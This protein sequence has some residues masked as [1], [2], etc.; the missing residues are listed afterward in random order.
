MNAVKYTETG[1]IETT[2]AIKETREKKV[3]EFVVKDTGGGIPENEREINVLNL[4]AVIIFPN[5][6]KRKNCFATIHQA[7][8]E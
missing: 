8:K 3:A 6:L 1:K 4:A 7:L 5:R 2:Y